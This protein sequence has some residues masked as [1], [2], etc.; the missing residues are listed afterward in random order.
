MTIHET[1]KPPKSVSSLNLF[2]ILDLPCSSVKYFPSSFLPV[3]VKGLVIIS[4]N[5]IPVSESPPLNIPCPPAKLEAI[6]DKPPRN[7]IA[8]P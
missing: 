5:P 2:K 6:P 7:A 8:I 1:H 3:E 4:L